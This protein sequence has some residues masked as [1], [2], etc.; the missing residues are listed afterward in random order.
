[1]NGLMH[2]VE[3]YLPAVTDDNDNSKLSM[4][5]SSVHDTSLHSGVEEASLY[6]GYSE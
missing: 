5:E 2:Q 4:N 1:M 6:D 3:E